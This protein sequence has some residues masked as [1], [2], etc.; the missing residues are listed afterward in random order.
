MADDIKAALV[1]SLEARGT[2]DTMRAEL[3]AAAL[4]IIE[5]QQSQSRDVGACLDQCAAAQAPTRRYITVLLTGR[6]IA[7]LSVF[8]YHCC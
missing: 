2:L 6:Y 8:S 5:Q 7:A 4:S 3:Q 1:E